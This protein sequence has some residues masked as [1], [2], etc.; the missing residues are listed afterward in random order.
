V[1]TVVS[2][3]PHAHLLEVRVGA[4]VAV[5]PTPL[6]PHAHLLE[7]RV[8]AVAEDTVSTLLL[9]AVMVVQLL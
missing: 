5:V 1:V 7:V 2:L 9:V 3:P 4:V 6:P 8:V